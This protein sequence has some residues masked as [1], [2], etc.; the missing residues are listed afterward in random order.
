MNIHFSDKTL[1][2]K[3]VSASI[4]KIEIGSTMYSL[5]DSN[6]DIDYLYV[7]ATSDNELNS[8]LKSH[9]QLQFKEDGID[10]NF[11]NIHQFIRNTISGD[12]TINY[13]VINSN[14]LLGTNLEFLY[15][16]R[17]SFSNYNIIRSYLGMC[18]RDNLHYFK[19]TDHR[20]QLKTI[21]HIYRGYYFAK[22]IMNNDFKLV[23]SDILS[24]SNEIRQ[25]GEN[26]FKSK[27]EYLT[28]SSLLVSDLR[29]ELNQYLNL[30]TLDMSKNMDINSQVLLDI[31]LNTLI[32]SDTYIENKNILK[33]FDMTCFYDS[34]ENWVSY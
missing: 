22:S 2:N 1:F 19:K 16:M 13:E 24:I 14:K 12:S 29:N 33:N 17:K 27:K 7:Y 4:L 28:K 20:D 10:H 8:F 3:L 25:I 26:D 32:N 30:K 9:H 15:N 6:S 18:K 5:N 21:I 31:N 11:I 23:N 34:F